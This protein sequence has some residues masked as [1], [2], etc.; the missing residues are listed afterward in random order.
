[1]L[2]KFVNVWWLGVKHQ[3][4]Y[5]L[6]WVT[7]SQDMTST[8]FLLALQI[9]YRRKCWYKTAGAGSWEENQII[10]PQNAVSWNGEPKAKSLELYKAPKWLLSNK[11]ANPVWYGSKQGY[12]IIVCQ[13]CPFHKMVSLT[14]RHQR[15][16]SHQWASWYYILKQVVKR[17]STAP[18]ER[19]R[20]PQVLQYT[21]RGSPLVRSFLSPSVFGLTVTH[22]NPL[23]SWHKTQA[24]VLV[25]LWRRRTLLCQQHTRL[26]P[27]TT[28]T[29]S[30]T[31]TPGSLHLHTNKSTNKKNKTRFRYS[32]GVLNSCISL[33][34]L[35]LSAQTP[36]S[37]QRYT[38]YKKTTR[39]QIG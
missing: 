8:L 22:T 27:A 16:K 7:Y 1:M 12:K 13:N 24:R 21:V 6:T 4:P 28:L 15:D 19:Q 33:C 30:H 35:S 18:R 17:F 14:P 37:H 26:S 38:L 3:V 39:T 2:I 11:I 31:H 5:L 36:L 32:R 23:I 34:I 29:C 10:K 25:F 20:A 9:T